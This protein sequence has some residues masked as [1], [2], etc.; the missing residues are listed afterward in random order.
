MGLDP[1]EDK[2]AKPTDESCSPKSRTRT[3][4]LRR[5]TPNVPHFFIFLFRYSC[6]SLCL[7]L[8]ATTKQQSSTA[9]TP[10]SQ[11]SPSTIAH[12]PFLIFTPRSAG[13][14]RNRRT[15]LSSFARISPIS[16]PLN[17][18]RRQP[19]VGVSANS[20]GT[21][22]QCMSLFRKNQSLRLAVVLLP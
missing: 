21:A 13:W 8:N 3:S 9:V 11:V 2:K 1:R 18:D 14:K 5:Q 4:T 22:N 15:S 10:A 12:F 19:R 17:L 6:M 20:F 7:P 16:T